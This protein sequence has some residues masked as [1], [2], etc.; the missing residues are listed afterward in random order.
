VHLA[1]HALLSV[2]LARAFFFRQVAKHGWPLLVAIVLAGTLADLDLLAALFGPAA[3]L[4]GR[5]TFT[6]SLLGTLAMILVSALIFRALNKSHAPDKR[7]AL[8]KD[9]FQVKDT[10]A[11]QTVIFLTL[12][13]AAVLH[14][15]LD[16]FSTSGVALFWP[17]QFARYSADWLPNIDP[18][19]FALLL[20]GLLLP[21]LRRLISSEIGAK[22]K[23]PRGQTGARVVFVL[24]TL[25]IGARFLLHSSSLTLLES[26]A[27]HGEIAAHVAAL[28]DALSP[29]LWSGIV[30][31]QSM[32]CTVPIPLAGKP[33]NS[34]AARCQHK[35]DISPALATAQQ[36]EV[37][38]KYLR[39]ARF[40]RASVASTTDGT[41]V[42][43][44]SMRDLGQ[45]D[46]PHAVAAQIL[47]DPHSR[48]VSEQIVWAQEIHER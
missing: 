23:S 18:W 48:I 13:L 5:Y 36:T 30:E 29:L 47:L 46:P 32:L 16:F 31:T 14:L 33:F 27:Y 37:G 2:V 10:F 15:L 39:A 21:E 43:I 11:P 26:R 28:P 6:H 12:A 20:A 8:D 3:Y 7:L 44:R 25:Y 17:F 22:E 42:A 9:R 35:P 40:P 38:Q 45:G 1:I 41:V 19:L 24:L 34:E 4:A